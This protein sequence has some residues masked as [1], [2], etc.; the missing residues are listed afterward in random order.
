MLTGPYAGLILLQTLLERLETGNHFRTS[1][2]YEN[3]AEG[4]VKVITSCCYAWRDQGSQVWRYF[5]EALSEL[6]W[7][8]GRAGP[9]DCPNTLFAPIHRTIDEYTLQ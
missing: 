9:Y 3:R 1:L 5:R 2:D 6:A 8:A 7:A 4:G